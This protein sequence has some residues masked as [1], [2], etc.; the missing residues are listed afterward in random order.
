MIL[1]KN[2]FAH[3]VTKQ[4]KIKSNAIICKTSMKTHIA[5]LLVSGILFLVIFFFQIDF[6][7]TYVMYII[8]RKHVTDI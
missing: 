1:I 2:R 3:I 4:L 5:L 6:L 8:S 7:P